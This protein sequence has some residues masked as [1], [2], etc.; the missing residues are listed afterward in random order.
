MYEAG[1]GT[2]RDLTQAYLWYDL[3]G[4]GGGAQGLEKRMT[5]SDIAEAQDLSLKWKPTREKSGCPA[6]LLEEIGHVAQGAVSTSLPKSQVI[7]AVGGDPEIAIENATGR[8]LNVQFTGPVNQSVTIPVG[9]SRTAT[10]LAGTYTVTAVISG[11]A[12]IGTST[13]SGIEAYESHFRYGVRYF[14]TPK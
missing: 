9:E 14:L 8:V 5:R 12:G 11:L 2:A 7:G 6:Y 4:R 13:L 3:V 10:L 1:E